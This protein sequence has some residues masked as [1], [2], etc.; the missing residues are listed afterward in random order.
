MRLLIVAIGSV[1]D[2]HPFLAIGMAAARRGHEVIVLTS[3]AFRGLVEVC[4]LGFRPIGTEEDYRQAMEDPRLWAPRTSFRTLWA[5]VARTLEPV[6]AMLHAEACER[7]VVLGSLWAFGARALRETHGVPFLSAQVS[8]STLLSAW[9]VPEHGR[10]VLP[11]SLPLIVKRLVVG[12]AEALMI[13]RVMAPR[14]D[15]FL[16][17]VGLAP[18]RRVMSRWMHSPDGVLALFPDWFAPA[19]P[20][21]PMPLSFTGFPLFEVPGAPGLDAELA[22]FLNAGSAPVVITAGSTLLSDPATLDRH[23][24]AVRQL[25]HRAIVLGARADRPAAGQDAQ[26]LQRHYVPLGPLLRRSSAIVH[27]GGIGTTAFALAAGVPQIV[28]PFAH[29]QFD[30]ARRVVRLGAGVRLPA[31]A[32]V[33]AVEAALRALLADDACRQRCAELS[34]RIDHEDGR[35]GDGVLGGGRGGHAASERAVDLAEACLARRTRPQAP[36]LARAPSAW[37]RQ[38]S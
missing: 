26:V 27:H 23:V 25:G 9:Q 8:P 24:A 2:V 3:P 30:N 7:T 6:H 38:A 14:L 22:D 19:Q 33:Q 29:D 31:A 5:L 34:L 13:D 11:D 4:R 10:L 1:G 36:P 28:T 17:R 32:S 20:D 21:W 35:G 12:L 15:A 16:R 37:A 18:V